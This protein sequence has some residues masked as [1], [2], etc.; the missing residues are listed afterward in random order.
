MPTYKYKAVD[1][2][3][4]YVRGK[5]TADSELEVE[6]LL[7]QQ[8]RT[9]ISIQ[10][11]GRKKSSVSPKKVTK[12]K[13]KSLITFTY[14]LATYLES[15]VP[16]MSALYDLSTSAEDPKMRVVVGEIYKAI[17]QG[18]SLEDALKAFP[19]IF[20]PLYIGAIRSGETT[21]N[22]AD[23]LRYLTGY[24]EWQAELKSQVIQAMIYPLI[25]T[26]AIGGAVIV[27][28][29][30][31]FP[32][33]VSIFKG[34]NI[35]LPLPTKILIW[36]SDFMRAH[37][38]ILVLIIIMLGIALKLFIRTEKGKFLFDK[39]K[40]HLPLFGILIKKV[41]ISRFAH[42]F[43]MALKSGIDVLRA[44]ALCKEVVGNKIIE[45]ELAVIMDKVNMGENLANSFRDASEFPALV[46]RMVAVG[47]AS[48]T[49][50][51][52]VAKISEYYDSEV[53][54]TINQVFALMEPILIVIMGIGVG[55]VAFSIFIPIFNI[56]K[57]AQLH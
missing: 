24:L 27:L 35:E 22:L 50:E 32:K 42:T 17:E 54:K 15:G 46:T 18:S 9:L 45:S 47:E 36:L 55:F 44:L 43:S 48:G 40:L 12:V 19:R 21:G 8:N 26:V 51:D 4:K 29:T 37:W 49:L 23:V 11:A 2:D 25:L 56:T 28:V 53:P 38:K 30:F 10:E 57:L 31:A 39:L 14:Q 16:L 33:F 52:T 5:I 34:M 13:T 6:R 7:S 20:G 3:G 1:S 41:S